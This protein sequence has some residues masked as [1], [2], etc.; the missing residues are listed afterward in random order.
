MYVCFVQ[1]SIVLSAFVEFL[2]NFIY[3]RQVYSLFL[4]HWNYYFTPIN[5]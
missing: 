1:N 4:L 5:I 3:K 2:V